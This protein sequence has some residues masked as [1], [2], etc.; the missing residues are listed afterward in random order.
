MAPI[1]AAILVIS[2]VSFQYFS[3]TSA[4]YGKH[5]TTPQNDG[6]QGLGSANAEHSAWCLTRSMRFNVVKHLLQLWISL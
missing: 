4:G 3:I 5:V 2:S 6:I 1:F